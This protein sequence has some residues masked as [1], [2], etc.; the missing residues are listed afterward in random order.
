MET[1]RLEKLL[2]EMRREARAYNKYLTEEYL[3]SLNPRVLAS[4]TEP[5]SRQEYLNRL[6]WIE[7]EQTER[8]LAREE[9]PKK[10]Y[11]GE[12]PP[13]AQPAI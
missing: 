3:K 11:P 1:A 13:S 6:K 12:Q 2:S 9:G 10:W 7:Q 8:E 5:E 4:L